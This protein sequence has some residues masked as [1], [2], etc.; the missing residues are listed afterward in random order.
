[1]THEEMLA[2]IDEYREKGHRVGMTTIIVG[3]WICTLDDV[4]VRAATPEMAWMAAKSHRQD[5]GPK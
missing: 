3:E 5:S 1:M 2:E 4:T